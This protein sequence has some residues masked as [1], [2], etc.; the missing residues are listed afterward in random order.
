MCIKEIELNIINCFSH[1]KFKVEQLYTKQQN[2]KQTVYNQ[3]KIK[4]LLW[5]II[6][7]LIFVVVVYYFICNK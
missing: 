7:I 1:Y 4:F 5:L 6:L 3:M 2:I